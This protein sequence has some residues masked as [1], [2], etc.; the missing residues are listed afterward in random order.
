MK[1]L[2][3]G[4]GKQRAKDCDSEERAANEVDTWSLNLTI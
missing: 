2:F 1:L 3:T 4:L